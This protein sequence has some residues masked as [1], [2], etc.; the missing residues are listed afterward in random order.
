MM[1]GQMLPA[2]VELGVID[3]EPGMLDIDG[4]ENAGL[5][6][7]VHIVP[8]DRI[9]QARIIQLGQSQGTRGLYMQ[10]RVGDECLVFYPGGREQGAV[11]LA[12]IGSNKSPMPSSAGDVAV[13]L[14][15]GGVE[16]RT[17][18][19]DVVRRVVHDALLAQLATYLL[20]LETFMNT[21][22]TAAT[23]AIIAGAATTFMTTVDP[24]A[25]L[26][27]DFRDSLVSLEY[28]SSGIKVT[29]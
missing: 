12:G 23:A 18:D 20:A 2:G 19:G 29:E 14:H 9:H 8:G 13:L 3:S 27:S 16:L 22:K 5:Y 7:C 6:A 15:D 4:Y 10:P 25:G 1:F 26:S 11:A 28:A 21:S 17:A 24:P